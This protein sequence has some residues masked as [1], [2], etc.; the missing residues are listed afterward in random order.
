MGIAFSTL[1]LGNIVFISILYLC[2]LLYTYSKFFIKKNSVNYGNFYSYYL[3]KNPESNMMVL[4]VLIAIPIGGYIQYIF[5][6]IMLGIMFL[7]VI[8]LF[9]IERVILPK[10]RNRQELLEKFETN[11]LFKLHFML[12]HYLIFKNFKKAKSPYLLSLGDS[13]LYLFLIIALFLLD[14]LRIF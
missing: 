14:I 13:L 8:V 7:I 6:T 1:I 2:F 12:S 3:K 9:E 5:S 4:F 11:N 10:I